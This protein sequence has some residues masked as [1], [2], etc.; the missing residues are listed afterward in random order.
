[1]D[2][3]LFI[4]R[5]ITKDPREEIEESQNEDFSKNTLTIKVIM[6]FILILTVH[7]YFFFVIPKKTNKSNIYIYLL[8]RISRIILSNICLHISLYIFHRIICINTI[9]I[10][11]IL[12]YIDIY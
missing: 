1:M 6:H 2:R 12:N 8:Y 4:I 7:Y 3:M 10:S 11:N 9:W 5:K